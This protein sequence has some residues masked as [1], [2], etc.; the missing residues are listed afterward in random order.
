MDKAIQKLIELREALEKAAKLPST[1]SPKLPTSPVIDAPTAPKQP[2]LTPPS[3]KDP[4]KVAQQLQDPNL[5]ASALKL[6]KNGQWSL[7]EPVE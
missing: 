6:A 4:T 1:K 2:D 3:K 7:E 5:K